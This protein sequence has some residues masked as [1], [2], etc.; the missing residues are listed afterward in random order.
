MTRGNAKRFF[1][2][3]RPWQWIKHTV[4]TQ[5]LKVWA[6]KVGSQAKTIWVIDAFAGAG[7]FRDAGTGENAPGSPLRAALVAKEYNEHPKKKTEGK[8]LRLICVE[9]DPEHYASLC[10]R[11]KGFGFVTVLHGEFGE[12]A[13]EIARMIG[14][15][16]ALVLLDPIGVKSIHADVC[17]KLLHRRGKT[18]A[19]VNVQFAVVHRAGGMLLP[20]GEPDPANAVAA[21]NVENID[22]FFGTK[23]WRKIALSGA[24]K[25][26][27]EAAYLRL[28]FDTVVG[29]RYSSKHAYPVRRTYEGPP[30]YFL[31]HIADHPDAEWLINDLLASVESRL[32]VQSREREDPNILERFAEALDAARL[33]TLHRD[34]GKEVLA[35]LRASRAQTLRYGS[36]CL[37]LR[38][39]YF[40][41]LKRG[42]YSKIVKKLYEDGQLKREKNGKHPAL[43]D[44]EPLFL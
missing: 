34:V 40:G 6:W 7:E 25:D 20:D 12:Q 30:R 19:F 16:P 31:A 44:D 32:Y 5:Y 33:E 1:R 24:S 42:D 18:D 38:R 3:V 21:G 41:K 2:T 26:D 22:E 29:P 27:R 43:T 15:D 13:D 37:A 14:H 39:A 8:T 17:R 36:V 9:R 4:F 10:E 11:L 23:D 28:Y 35:L